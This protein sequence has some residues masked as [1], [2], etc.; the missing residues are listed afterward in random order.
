[1]KIIHTPLAVLR[2]QYGIV[3]LPLQMIEERVVARVGSE[4]PARLFT[5]AHWDC[6]TQPWATHWATCGF[7]S[8][9][10]R[11]PNVAMRSVARPS[12]TQLRIKHG[13][14]PMLT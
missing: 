5:S 8:V 10:T 11:S 3:R 1:M 9:A 7:K 14:S 12:S 4:A 13:S 6:W 2:F